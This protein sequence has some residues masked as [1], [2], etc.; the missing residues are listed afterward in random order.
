[1]S[2]MWE[3]ISLNKKCYNIYM[4]IVKKD[5]IGVFDS[6]LGGLWI[7]KHLREKLPEYNYVFLGDQL[8][9]PYGGK[10]PDELFDI[11][12]A[13]LDFLYGKQNCA[14]VILA[15]NT[16]SSTIYDRLRDWKDEHYFGKI[17]F[18]IVRPTIDALSADDHTV[19]FATER[20]CQSEI[21]ENF[22]KTHLKNYIKIP[23]PELANKIERG[24][25]TLSYISEFKDKVS[26]DFT[27]GALLCTH[28]GIVR[29]DFK[30][31]Y[32]HINQWIYQEEIIPVYM[33]DYFKEFPE[34]EAFFK[35]GGSLSI[36]VTKENEIFN[37]FKKDWFGEDIKSE[38]VIL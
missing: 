25:D 21:Y 16:I 20:T 15:C 23:L 38:L 27:K 30:K 18:G 33:A 1:M 35:H 7:L 26:V 13:G 5:N 22:F 10:T 31:V 32:P 4:D 11:A 19:I 8:N 12:V 6:G 29:E 3:G 14:G 2:D 36:L 37:N 9:V 24:S 17:L 28:Y 34:R